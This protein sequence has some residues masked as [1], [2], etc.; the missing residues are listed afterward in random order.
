VKKLVVLLAAG[1]VALDIY[2]AVGRHI[3]T[4]TDAGSHSLVWNAEGLS[5]GV[6]FCRLEMN[7]ASNVQRILLVR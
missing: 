2:D 7:G 6:Y 4:L 3:Q 1:R 5:A